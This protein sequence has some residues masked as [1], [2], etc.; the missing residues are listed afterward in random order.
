MVGV[1][2]CFVLLQARV[3]IGAEEAGKRNF[4]MGFTPFPYDISVEAVGE[5]HKFIRENA[6]ILAHHIEG[7]PWTEALNEQPFSKELLKEWQGNTNATPPRGKVYLAVSPG[8]GDLKPAEKALPLS[9]ELRGKPYDDPLVRKAYLAYCRRVV[10]FFKPDYLCIG[11]EVNEIHS[12]GADKWRAYVALH[13]FVYEELKKDHPRL[14]IF[15]SFTLHGMLNARGEKRDAM[16]AAF[17]E[18]MPHNDLVAV[19]FY[20][21]LAGGTTDIAGA[22]DFMTKHFDEYKKPYAVVETGEAAERLVFP[23]SKQVVAGTPE[24]QRAYYETLLAAAQERRFAFVITFLHR[25]YDALWEKIQKTSPEAFMAWRDC[26]LLD[27]SGRP[28]PAFEVWKKYFAMPRE[29]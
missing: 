29:P 15:A 25:D 9:K 23:K 24:K 1:V 5:S 8:R 12:A 16:L 18:L 19:S 27:E 6:D 3:G 7:V 11:I 21:F 10:E 20:P 4:L 14:P 13:K 17:R 26:G 2:A 28:R 22:L